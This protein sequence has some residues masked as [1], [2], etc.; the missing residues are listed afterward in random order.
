MKNTPRLYMLTILVLMLGACKKDILPPSAIT[1]SATDLSNT[2]AKFN[3]T[4][5]PNNGSTTVSFDYGLTASYGQTTQVP[6]PISGSTP[7]TIT[8]DISGLKS[9]LTYHYRIKAVNEK[10]TTLGEDMQFTTPIVDLDGN[11]Y[12]AVTIGSQTWMVENLK[13]TKFND[14]TTIPNITNSTEWKV[15]TTSA[16]SWYNNDPTT[17]KI[18]YGGL[19]NWYAV[20]TNKLCPAGWHVPSDTEWTT[21]TTFLGGEAVAGGKLKE[22]GLLHWW[23]PNFGATNESGFTA[24]PVGSRT[25]YGDFN[26]NGKYANF[27]SST[28][29]SSTQSLYRSIYYASQG[30]LKLNTYYK[31]GYSIRCIRD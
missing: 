14:G 18:I 13:T 28:I 12:N 11:A 2:S 9:G 5:N 31:E 4:V 27:W 7:E 20:N 15:L 24:L 22:T 19:Y 1:L 29:N 3:G 30:V 10:G 21:L 23:D 25:I 16:F 6:A 26:E 17:Y 8:S